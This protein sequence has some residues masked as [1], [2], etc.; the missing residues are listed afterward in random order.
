[1]APVRIRWMG[2][3]GFMVRDGKTA[4]IDPWFEGNPKAAGPVDSAPEADVILLTHDHF[5][6]AS[7]AVALA[8]RT[9]ALMVGIFELAG[10]LKAL[11]R[12]CPYSC[13]SR[14]GS[15]CAGN[16]ERGLPWKR[17]LETS[18]GSFASSW[19]LRCS[20]WYSSA[21]RRRGDGSA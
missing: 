16:T 6:H 8:K 4:L 14:R 10:D 1:M 20:R 15:H 9:K 11:I 17:T 13:S 19:G 12:T 21:R 7:D 3:S 5:D 18:T 2:H